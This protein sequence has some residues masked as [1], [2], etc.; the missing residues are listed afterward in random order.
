MT[1][2]LATKKGG[3]FYFDTSVMDNR[4]RSDGVTVNGITQ[5]AHLIPYSDDTFFIFYKEKLEGPELD[6]LESDWHAFCEKTT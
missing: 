3:D 1:S 5:F 2:V 4:I 6:K